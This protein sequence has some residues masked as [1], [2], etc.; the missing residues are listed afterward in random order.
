MGFEFLNHPLGYKRVKDQ[1]KN[2]L[3]GRQGWLKKKIERGD[4]VS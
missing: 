3:K 2:V 1:A 4:P